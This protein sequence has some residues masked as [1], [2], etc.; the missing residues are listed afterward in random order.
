M[1]VAA[2]MVV[3]VQ[4]NRLLVDVHSFDFEVLASSRRSDQARVGPVVGRTLGNAVNRSA[5][6][7]SAELAVH[8]HFG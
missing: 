7:V 2:Q 1:A 8:I 3:V 5:V 4:T 6:A